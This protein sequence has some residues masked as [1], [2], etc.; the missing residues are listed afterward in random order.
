MK[1]LLA[2][3]SFLLISSAALAQARGL[4]DFSEL[5]ER[6]GPAVVNISTTQMTRGNQGMQ[7]PFDENDPAF[8]FFKRF[9]VMDERPEGDDGGLFRKLHRHLDCSGDAEAESGGLCYRD[10][11]FIASISSL[12]RFAAAFCSAR[13]PDTVNG[14]P[15]VT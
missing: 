9:A 6:Q 4:P 3:F 12:R 1:R 5:A 15:K 10:F 7:F 8:E 13:L 2:L 11:H 14:F